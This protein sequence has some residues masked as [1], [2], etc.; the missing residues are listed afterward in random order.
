[1]NL[2]KEQLIQAAHS[3]ATEVEPPPYA[4]MDVDITIIP[5][6]K[7]RGWLAQWG[8]SPEDTSPLKESAII[9]R[10]L[11]LEALDNTVARKQQS[12]FEDLN[13]GLE[14]AETKIGTLEHELGIRLGVQQAIGQENNELRKA[15]KKILEAVYVGD[16]KI[17]CPPALEEP[18]RALANAMDG[19]SAGEKA[20]GGSNVCETCDAH[21]QVIEEHL[22]EIEE[23]R[24]ACMVCNEDGSTEDVTPAR[25]KAFWEAM[26][27][28]RGR[29]SEGEKT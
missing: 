24:D 22:A 3:V 19:N 20:I 27:Q 21:C 17:L 16:G 5:P 29:I 13:R 6:N 26:I 14:E 28:N 2:T 8:E 18:I 15:G 10:A 11:V 12:I 9:I 1:M 23:W 7:G 25:A 4:P